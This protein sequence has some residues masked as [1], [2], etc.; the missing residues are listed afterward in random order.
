M[1]S[2]MK[3]TFL[4]SLKLSS[5][6][7]SS[8]P[9][10]S[11]S[12]E[13]HTSAYDTPTIYESP[14]PY[15]ISMASLAPFNTPNFDQMLLFFLNKEWPFYLALLSNTLYFYHRLYRA[16][17]SG[18]LF[19]DEIA[20]WVALSQAPLLLHISFFTLRSNDQ[21]AWMSPLHQK[22]TMWGFLLLVC[23]VH[24]L[25]GQSAEFTADIC[26]KLIILCV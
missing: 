2:I 16:L 11:V 14:P 6:D 13:S 18:V 12:S 1:E 15:S 24:Q 5:E 17:N 22:W 7:Y 19:A 4:P 20:Y 8:L 26:G 10:Y 9:Q 21:L 23:A 25:W 3:K